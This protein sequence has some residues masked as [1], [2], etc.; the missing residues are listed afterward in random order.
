MGATGIMGG[1][2]LIPSPVPRAFTLIE[3][4]VVIAIVAVLVGV[5]LPALSK[6]RE[7]G[8]SVQCLANLRSCASL[9]QMYADDNKGSSP[10]LG[11]PYDRAPNW[12]VVV[13]QGAGMNTTSARESRH[14]KSVLVC[15]SNASFYGRAMLRTYAMNVTGRAGQPGDPSSF[16]PAAGDP[17][18]QPTHIRT[19]RVAFPSQMP[20]LMDAQTMPP[21]SD[22]T[23]SLLCASVMDFRQ[24]AHVDGRLG[25]FHGRRAGGSA[26]TPGQSW[27]TSFYDSSARSVREIE[28]GWLTPLP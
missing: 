8:R 23:P 11:W 18:P 14:E 19:D 16:E 28:N 6:G 12:A 10:A 7:A 25:R 5:L 22:G 24:Q 21:A 13:Q 2:G 4:L 15:G 17:N 3:V 26:N 27:N 1:D 20:M 9:V